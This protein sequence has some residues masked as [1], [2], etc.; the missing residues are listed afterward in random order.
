MV[1]R[2]I[3][4]RKSGLRFRSRFKETINLGQERTC[5]YRRKGQKLHNDL[6]FILGPWCRKITLGLISPQSEDSRPRATS[7]PP[8]LALGFSTVPQEMHS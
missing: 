4:H 2:P 8:V 5:D 1:L 6:E 3:R 7:L